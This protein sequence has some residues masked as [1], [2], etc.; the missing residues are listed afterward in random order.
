MLNFNLWKRQQHFWPTFNIQIKTLLF[1][2]LSLR[3]SNFRR[4]GRRVGVASGLYRTRGSIR[5]R[6]CKKKVSNGL[7]HQLWLHFAQGIECIPAI[8]LWLVPAFSVI[9][10]VRTADVNT[11]LVGVVLSFVVWLPLLPVCEDRGFVIWKEGEIPLWRRITQ[12][13]L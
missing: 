2:S 1:L 5:N 8:V 9:P 3:G 7:L 6:L 11:V 12:A 13:W 10:L 4:G